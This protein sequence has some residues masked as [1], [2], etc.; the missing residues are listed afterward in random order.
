MLIKLQK[1]IRKYHMLCPGDT[2][3]CAV[4]GGADSMALLWGMCC[5]AEKWNIT[6][7]AAHF[8]HCLRGE[9][10]QRDAEF[11][12]DF[13]EKQGIVCHMSAEQ[14]V[15]GKKGLEAA[16]REARYRFLQ[17][18][19]GK[20]ATAHTAGDNAE[21][22]LLHLLRGTG[23]KGLG[24]IA[25]VSGNFIRPMLDITRREVLEFLE[26]YHIPYV[27]DSTNAEDAF[28]RNRLRHKIMPILQQENPRVGENLSEMAQRLRWDEAFIDSQVPDT[29]DVEQLRTLHPALRSRA[30]AQ[31]L[32]KSGVQ[33]P[34][35]EH[36]LLAESLVFSENPSAKATFS[37]GIT[38]SRN[39]GKL[40]V[41]EGK[42]RLSAT[43][44]PTSGTVLLP[45]YRVT[46]RPAAVP[47]NTPY[48]F[49]V[50]PQGQMYV[51]SR[52]AGDR[53]RLSGGTKTLKKLFIDKKIPAENR[54]RIP[55]LVDAAGILGVC[56]F[57]ANSSRAIEN[58]PLVQVLFE[59][60]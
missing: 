5:L 30:L 25:P 48:C 55:V 46:C 8:N 31:F 16:A 33:E 34:E 13:C 12:K 52:Q 7:E 50:Q 2:V 19:P 9:E 22:V 4:S 21:T 35:T 41:S 39:Y 18:L 24:G 36:I 43:V 51:R 54:K 14:V 60:I 37:N 58:T 15:S 47:E 44:L 6:V 1:F 56:G 27:E 28:L 20:V 10:S 45:G 57:G 3:I 42:D 59:E 49:T 29:E 26:E 17:S 40:Q 32:K 38:I 11:V 23:L 53:I